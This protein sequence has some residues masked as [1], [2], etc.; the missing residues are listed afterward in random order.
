MSMTKTAPPTVQVDIVS[1]FVCPWCWLGT[2]Y[3]ERAAKQ[4][5]FKTNLTWRPYMLDPN[6]PEGGVPYPDYMKAKFGEQKDNRF[7]SMR[8]H[9]E[10]AAPDAGIEFHFSDIPMRPNTL[11]AHRLMRWAQGQGKGDAAAQALFRTFFKDLKD[12]GDPKT[13]TGV[14]NEIGLET[15]VVCDLLAG[16]NDKDTVRGEIDY[17][18]GLGVSGVPTFIYN[19]QFAV[20]GAQPVDTHLQALEKAANTP[21]VKQ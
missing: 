17:F 9:L 16:D 14:A 12:I 1:D 11:D 15:D 21:P 4:S 2:A 19:G 13:L 18:R 3:F 8:Q 6:V 5:A 7:A 10:A 20:T